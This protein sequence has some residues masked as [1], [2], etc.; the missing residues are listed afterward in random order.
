MDV[1][2]TLLLC[3]CNTCLAA[4]VAFGVLVLLRPLL[5]PLVTPQQRVWMWYLFWYSIPFLSVWN[6]FAYPG[7]RILPITVWDLLGVPSSESPRTLFGAPAFL[8]GR[9]GGPGIYH[10]TLPGGRQIPV[11]LTDGLCLVLAALYLASIAAVAVWMVRRS[12]ALRNVGRQGT[13]VRIRRMRREDFWG[14]VP[15]PPVWVASGLPASF[16]LGDEIYLQKE[17]PPQRQGLVLLHETVHVQLRHSLIKFWM[18]CALAV[19]WWNPLIWLGYRYTCLD[20]ELACDARTMESLTPQERQE[21]ARTLVDLGSGQRHWEAP[22]SFGESDGARRVKALLA[23]K[24]ASIPRRL[25][26]LCVA[27]AVMC[28]FLGMP[29]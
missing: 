17:L 27:L 18:S 5:V 22:L 28:L 25:L 14:D 23:W 8:P 6:I 20:M 11:E 16:I 4:G 2:I 7:F 1:L 29:V 21:Y 9:Y 26:G 13:R 3:F 19:G 12:H 10:L 24:S 15:D